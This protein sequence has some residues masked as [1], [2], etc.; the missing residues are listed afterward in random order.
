[1]AKNHH[2]VPQ[3]WSLNDWRMRW[4]VTLW[5][6]PWCIGAFWLFPTVIPRSINYICVPLFLEQK[7]EDWA[8]RLASGTLREAPVQELLTHRA[9]SLTHSNN[10]SADQG[11]VINQLQRLDLSEFHKS[12]SG[13]NTT[14]EPQPLDFWSNMYWHVNILIASISNWLDQTGCGSLLCTSLNKRLWPPLPLLSSL[15]PFL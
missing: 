15:F 10:N 9:Q 3:C 11:L 1:M 12:D 6:T 2:L 5:E 7:R 8:V 13:L 4:P 14:S